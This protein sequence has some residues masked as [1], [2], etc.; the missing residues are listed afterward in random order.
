MVAS[1]LRFWLL[2]VLTIG[3]FLTAVVA[4]ILSGIR[5]LT[6]PCIWLQKCLNTVYLY[7]IQSNG[8]GFSFSPRGTATLSTSVFFHIKLGLLWKREMIER[9]A[10]ILKLYTCWKIN[11]L[12][13]WSA[14]LS[15]LFPPTSAPS[16]KSPVHSE[17]PREEKTDPLAGVGG[18]SVH[19]WWERQESSITFFPAVAEWFWGD[20]MLFGIG[21]NKV[22]TERGGTKIS[23]RDMG[24]EILETKRS[25]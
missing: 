12:N 4:K 22:L 3:L 19:K 15:T 23:R 18:F 17:W 11:A 8:Y 1:R 13:S 6:L 14:F 2:R 16:I 10:F 5:K 25:K 9:P 7:F 24:H 21:L 20:R